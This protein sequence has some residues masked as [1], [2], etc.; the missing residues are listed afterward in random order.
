MTEWR[1]YKDCFF[2]EE[3]DG[4]YLI[5]EKWHID[6]KEL[7]VF[8]LHERDFDLLCSTIAADGS[9]PRTVHQI[10]LFDIP[11]TV[12]ISHLFAAIKC[13]PNITSVDL[14]GKNVFATFT[15]LNRIHLAGP[16]DTHY[17]GSF[18]EQIASNKA[19]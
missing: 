4:H 6:D 14:S 19:L 13:Q 17:A 1:L 16:H 7:Y 10:S 8:E 15:R 3:S 9:V 11:T 12:N 2:D 18:M 5:R